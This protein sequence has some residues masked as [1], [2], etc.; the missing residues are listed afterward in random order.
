MGG[1][2][3]PGLSAGGA[4]DD[5]FEGLSPQD[6]EAAI[7]K[8]GSMKAEMARRRKAWLRGAHT[9]ILAIIVIA[10][11]PFLWRAVHG[12]SI[13]VND[14][15]QAQVARDDLGAVSLR[16]DPS[17]E[18]PLAGSDAPE[19]EP[20]PYASLDEDLPSPNVTMAATQRAMA[21]A[22]AVYRTGGFLGWLAAAQ[23]CYDRLDRANLEQRIYCL[24]LDAAAYAMERAAPEAFQAA[25]AEHSPYF[26]SDVF[27][28]RQLEFAP[29]SNPAL[30]DDARQ[31]RKREVLAALAMIFNAAQESSLSQD[32]EA[33]TLPK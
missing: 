15:A 25:D 18:S 11:A 23:D 30:S 12:V 27:I 31:R 5:P 4:G 16:D 29:P 19:R 9:L 7:V 22:A 21:D 2:Y 6:R 1:R 24:Q 10:V 20:Q 8:L 3:E 26:T 13:P 17:Q 14:A 32:G 33:L 28:E